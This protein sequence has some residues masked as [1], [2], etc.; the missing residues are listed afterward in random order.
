MLEEAE[1]GLEKGGVVLEEGELGLEKEEVVL[2]E[3]ERGGEA[4]SLLKRI[5]E[6][7]M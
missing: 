6:I 7:L 5:Q 3:Y 1:L 4:F 2:N